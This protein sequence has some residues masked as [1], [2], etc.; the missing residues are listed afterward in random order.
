MI[1]KEKLDEIFNNIN[2]DLPVAILVHPSPD[3]DCIGSAVGLSVFLQHVYGLTSKIYH[4]GE[5]SHPENKSIKEGSLC[6]GSFMFMLE[7]TLKQLSLWWA[8]QELN[9][10]SLP[11][12]GSVIPLNHSPF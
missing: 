7:P 9:L 2:S 5:I 8:K 3:P 4:F 1:E 12:E 11:C 10:R 6:A